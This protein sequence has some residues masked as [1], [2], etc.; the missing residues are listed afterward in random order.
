[1]SSVNVAFLHVRRSIDDTIWAN[2]GAKLGNVG[3]VRVTNKKL[4]CLVS[5]ST[6]QQNSD[7]NITVC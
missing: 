1:M 4:C 2:I 3:Q 6:V 7:E 5:Y